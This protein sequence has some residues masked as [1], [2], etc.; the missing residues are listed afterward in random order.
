[1]KVIP[2]IGDHVVVTLKGQVT[3][4]EGDV[5]DVASNPHTEAHNRIF[6]S[7]SHVQAIRK[8][9]APKVELGPGDVVYDRG[10]PHT[11]W[12]IT[13]KGY[14]ILFGVN[15]GEHRVDG[16][17]RWNDGRFVKVSD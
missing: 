12:L 11:R 3:W 15:K 13:N 5:F 9:A 7:D 6:P 8:I 16:T 14:V 10:R 2:Q 17:T 1:M 4:Q